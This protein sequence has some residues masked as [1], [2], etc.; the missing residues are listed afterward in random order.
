MRSLLSTLICFLYIASVAIAETP[1]QQNQF[2]ENHIR[3]LLVEHCYDCHSAES[4]VEA[5]L[6]LDSQAGWKKGGDS[7]AAIIPGDV[8]KSLLIEA[9]SYSNIDLQMP[10]DGK[11]SDDQ[12]TLLKQ[13]VK[14]GAA[15]P[16]KQS[17]ST[18]ENT[19]SKK[20]DINER[21]EQ[22]WCW[23]PIACPS[24]PNVSSDWPSKGLDHFILEKLQDNDLQ[25]ASPADKRTFL[26]RA[27]F[28]AIGLPPTLEEIERYLNDDSDDA[29]ANVIDRLLKSPHFG[30][31]WAQHWLDLMR[32]AETRGHEQD[33][34]IPEAYR[35]RDYV[36]QAL[37]EDVP[38]DQFVVE[39]I[40]GDLLETPRLH[41]EDRTNQSVQG[42]GFWQ[43]HDATHSPVDIRGEEAL[44]IQ[45]QIDVF[46]RSFLGLSLGCA[47]CHDHKFDA[48][49]TRDYYAMYG[50]LQSSSYHLADVSDPEKQAAAAKD[51]AKLNVDHAETIHTLVADR[52]VEQTKRLPDYLLHALDL[53]ASLAKE[54]KLPDAVRK[55]AKEKDLDAEVLW[56]VHCRLHGE[57]GSDSPLKP[58][59]L[60]A[61]TKAERTNE[62]VIEVCSEVIDLRKKEAQSIQK[63]WARLQVT[64]S[65]KDGERNYQPKDRDWTEADVIEEFES[66]AHPHWITSGHRFGDGPT[67]LGTMLLG[68][69]SDRPVEWFA[70]GSVACE[71]VSAKLSGLLRTRTFEITG[72]TIWYRCRGKGDIF[73]AVDSHRVVAGP[74]H[75]R[76]KKNV[77][78]EHG[79]WTWI[80]QDVRDY[81][82]HRVHI[83]LIGGQGFAVDRIIF[84]S[85]K[86]P[87]DA[88]LETAPLDGVESLEELSTQTT[89]SFDQVASSLRKGSLT[90]NDARLLNWYIEHSDMFVPANNKELNAAVTE[91]DRQKGEFESTIP[92]PIKVLSLLDGS[93]ENEPV[94]IRG[95]HRNRSEDT[96]P[97]GWL[98]ALGE[99]EDGNPA[100]SGRLRLAKKLV[101]PSN[102][103]LARVYVNRVWHHLFGRGI[104]ESVDDFGVMGKKPTHPELLDYLA[105][106][107][108]ENG[109]STKWLLREIMLSSTFHMSSRT[110]SESEQID[111]TNQLLHRMPIR[112]LTGEVIR[113]HLLAVSGRLDR[114]LYG[115]SV[116]VHITPFMRGNRTPKDSGPVDGDGRRSIYTEIRRNHLPSFLAAFD[117]PPPFMAIGKRTVS[118]SPTQSLI[119]LNDPLVHDQ[120]LLW[121]KRLLENEAND[122][123]RIAEA[124]ELAFARQPDQNEMEASLAFLEQQQEAYEEENAR[125]L[126]WR[127]LC[128]TLVNVKEFIHVN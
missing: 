23:Q 67:K 55:V 114:K 45:N 14:S 43:L 91:Y 86:P 96:V 29:T 106:Q 15:D 8:E 73:L 3:P 26:R 81:V 47:R 126:A 93:G 104:V 35:Y 95:S 27:T 87:A 18:T 38:Y 5:G 99:S 50:Y 125:E 11:L 24:P 22:H 44:R 84:A 12:I 10:P 77:K 118:N 88:L 66:T 69:T 102:P 64:K 121:A 17:V 6:S 70:D 37:N 31:N 72:D 97:R 25:P 19:D 54:E 20:F 110:D 78:N 57:L 42:T 119:L 82:G 48:I 75:G 80:S 98:V 101:D 62:R 100:G 40:A 16:R 1:E 34:A 107:F 32:F 109:W 108:V 103:L 79:S 113:D 61:A 28:A 63:A 68:R 39:H 60:L 116:Q 58:W 53:E 92:V 105:T 51:L 71:S 59:A 89:A 90:A 41:P 21:R 127:D 83:E 30:E 115:K 112:R 122:E 74:L 94:H 120:A 123:A 9:V 13:W 124:F 76:V 4:D 49:S 111:P 33:F 52:V 7:G 36:I 65:E 85:K 46:S 117:K 56:N 128:H 2:F